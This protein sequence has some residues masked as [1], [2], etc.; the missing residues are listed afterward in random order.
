[1]STD[2][3]HEL[4]GSAANLRS[5]AKMVVQLL[6]LGVIPP[7]RIEQIIHKVS[8][9]LLETEDERALASLMKVLIAAAKLGIEAQP[10]EH[11]HA[12]VHATV[13]DEQRAI[14][15][16]AIE[17]M[18]ELERRGVVINGQVLEVHPTQ[19]HTETKAI[20]RS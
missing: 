10:K 12:H 7:E 13:T 8:Y 4:L 19:A 3:R 11:H 1:M 9:R 18:A 17:L 16:R 15:E 20:S 14:V 2:N 5:D 6:T